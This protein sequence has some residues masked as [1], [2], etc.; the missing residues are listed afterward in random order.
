MHLHG[1][2]PGTVRSD[3]VGDGLDVRRCGAAATPD[4]VDQ[5]VLGKTGQVAGHHLRRFVV[6]AKCVREPWGRE[7]QT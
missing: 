1:R 6:V 5:S 4:D 3:G 7:K 2:D